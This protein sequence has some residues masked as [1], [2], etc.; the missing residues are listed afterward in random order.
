MV[1]TEA[2][3]DIPT[4]A[5]AP[6]ATDAPLAASLVRLEQIADQIL[7]QLR[8]RDEQVVYADFSVSKLMAGIAQVVALAALFVSYLNRN[9]PSFQP[10]MLFA[11]FVQTLTIALL[12]MGKQR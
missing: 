1:G 6:Q 5:L 7:N 10:L 3:A 12:I 9:D 8:K 4:A 2:A 11:I